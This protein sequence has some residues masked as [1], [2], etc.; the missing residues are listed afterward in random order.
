MSA[1]PLFARR[2]A[3]SAMICP[4]EAPLVRM[5]EPSAG[6]RMASFSHSSTWC[7]TIIAAFSPEPS[8]QLTTEASRSA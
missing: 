4:I 2:A 8:V 3:A 1:V 7:S 5:P 6:Q